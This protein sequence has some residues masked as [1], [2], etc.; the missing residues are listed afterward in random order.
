MATDT[1]PPPTSNDPANDGYE[2]VN[3]EA[4]RDAGHDVDDEVREAKRDVDQKARTV[5]E[6]LSDAIEDVIPGDSD[7]DGH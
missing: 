1:T 5:G 3:A 2:I 7:H 6:R 4:R